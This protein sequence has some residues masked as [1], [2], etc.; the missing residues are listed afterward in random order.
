[1]LEEGDRAMHF[2]LRYVMEGIVRGHSGA[3]LWGC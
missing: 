1:M 2:R 3:L